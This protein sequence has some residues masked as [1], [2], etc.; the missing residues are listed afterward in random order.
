MADLARGAIGTAIEVAVDDDPGAYALSDRDDHEIVDPVAPPEPLLCD[1]QGVA[2]VLYQ[3]RA[4]QALGDGGSHLH[5][6]P[7]EERC[8]PASSG[9]GLDKARKTYAYPDDFSHTDTG[10]VSGIL[11]RQTNPVEHRDRGRVLLGPSRSWSSVTGAQ[12]SS[13]ISE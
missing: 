6:C 3:Y 8:I 7:P 9:P 11:Y 1:G 10:T 4:V 2:V 5:I 13:T 12:S